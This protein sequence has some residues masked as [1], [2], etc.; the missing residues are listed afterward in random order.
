MENC[1]GYLEGWLEAYCDTIESMVKSDLLPEDDI[2][3]KAIDKI[4]EYIKAQMEKHTLDW[5]ISFQKINSDTHSTKQ[6]DYTIK[7][8][9]K[10]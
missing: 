3:V 2:A 6:P 8:G 9:D 4:R 10:L 7:I 5:N 1:K